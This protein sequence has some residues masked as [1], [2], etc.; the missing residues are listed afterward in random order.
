MNYKLCSTP[1]CDVQLLERLVLDLFYFDL[2]AILSC[3]PAAADRRTRVS[4]K[5]YFPISSIS[6]VTNFLSILCRRSRNTRA[7]SSLQRDQGQT[8][9][10]V[11]WRLYSL[12][13]LNRP[14]A[15]D[16]P[17]GCGCYTCIYIHSKH[18]R[19]TTTTNNYLH[20]DST[21][22]LD[23]SY[24]GRHYGTSYKLDVSLDSQGQRS[25]AHL[26]NGKCVQTCSHHSPIPTR[27]RLCPNCT[28]P[29]KHPDV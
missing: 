27:P 24:Y 21:Y 26:Y 1:H 12:E 28:C 3:V 29:V 11:H 23:T 2:V 19:P 5:D 17:K 13:R 20:P 14:R 15:T 7:R 4:S 18:D 25:E 16:S 10:L 8:S 22:H 6:N 9:T